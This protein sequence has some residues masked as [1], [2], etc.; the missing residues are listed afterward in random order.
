MPSNGVWDEA[1]VLEGRLRVL[2][3]EGHSTNEIGR[4]LGISKNA[5]VGKAGRLGLEGRVSP[6][7]RD[8]ERKPRKPRAIG[9]K[10]TLPPIGA[11]AV[12][13]PPVS[14]FAAPAEIARPAMRPVPIPASEFKPLAKRGADGAGCQWIHGEPGRGGRTRVCDADIS[15]LCRHRVW[16]EAH[17]KVVWVKP[18]DMRDDVA[19]AA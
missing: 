11:L 15:P 17:R 18:R 2:W 9:A 4:R 8:G 1:G 7:K 14:H 6:I 16:C 5:V 13:P 10:P 19:R 3:A 12:L